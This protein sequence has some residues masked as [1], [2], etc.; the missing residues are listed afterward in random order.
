MLVVHIMRVYLSFNPGYSS[1]NYLRKFFRALHPKWREKVTAIEEL[2]ELTSLSLDELIGNLKVHEMIIKKDSEIVKAKWRKK[3]SCF[4]GKKESDEE[5]FTTEVKMK[6][7][8]MA[9]EDFNK[10]KLGLEFNSFEASSGTKEIK[11]VKAQKKASSDGGSINMGGPHSVQATPKAIMGPPP[12]STPGSEKNVSFQKS[13]LGPRPKHII[14][15]NV[16]VPV[17]SDNEVKQ[18]YKTLSKPGVRFS[19][20]NYR[21]KTPPP[22][23]VNNNYP[24]PKTPQ[25]KRNV[26]TKAKSTVVL[27]LN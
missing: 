22:R 6:K 20:P 27:S 1:K 18:F 12:V 3:I 14:V 16:K 21:S 19:K 25:P 11:F 10:E 9:L 24:L 26:E 13:I 15:N 5:M 17:A 8:S 23:S 4:K 7:Y 2:K